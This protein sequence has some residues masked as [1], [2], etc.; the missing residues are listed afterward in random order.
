[1]AITFGNRIGGNTS[2]AWAAYPVTDS[3][4]GAAVGLLRGDMTTGVVTSASGGNALTSLSA[5][6][7]ATLSALLQEMLPNGAPLT[8]PLAF[9]RKLVGA[10]GLTNS[11]VITLTAVNV[12]VQNYELRATLTAAG[13]MLVYVPNSAAC[14]LYTGFGADADASVIPTTQRYDAVANVPGL[15]LAGAVALAVPV[16]VGAPTV[17][18]STTLSAGYAEVD[19]TAARLFRVEKIN[20]AIADP[21]PGAGTLLFDLQF[22]ASGLGGNQNATVVNIAGDLTVPAGWLYRVVNPAVGDATL[23]DVALTVAGS[24]AL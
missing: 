14:G 10:V 13:T 12:G 20:R 16:A 1:M 8:N 17:T 3:V 19:A 18:L 15:Y 22:A 9:L 6:E 5:S 11:D 24:I 21:G 23:A 7:L 4:G 2:G